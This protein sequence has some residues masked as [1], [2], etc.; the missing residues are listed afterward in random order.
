MPRVEVNTS[1]VVYMFSVLEMAPVVFCPAVAR[2]SDSTVG[3]I[4]VGKN[5]LISTLS[6]HFAHC[7]ACSPQHASCN[8]RRSNMPALPNSV[9][10]TEL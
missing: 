4:S 9:L 5:L 6:R 1:L 3:A 2:R 7:C 8:R 10:S